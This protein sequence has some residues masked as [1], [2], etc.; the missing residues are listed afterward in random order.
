MKIAYIMLCHKNSKQINMLI[1][2]LMNDN[3]DFYIHVDLKSKIGNEISQK[4]NIFILP[5][6]KSYSVS[7]GGNEMILATLSLIREVKN[8]GKKYDY[9]WL[10]SGQDF[11]IVS[12]KIIEQRLMDNF[13]YNFIDI[14]DKEYK[15]YNA[16]KKL[17]EIKYPKWITKNKFYIKLI[18][19]IYMILTGGLKY[20]FKIFRRKRNFDFDFY[21][22]SQ[23]WT[24][25]SECAYDLLDYCDENP[26]YIKYFDN[27]I[28][29]DE[30]FFQTLFMNTKYSKLR[31]DNL[32]FVNW[33]NNKRSPENLTINDLS[34]LKQISKEKCLAR[35]FDIDVDDE[36]ILMLNENMDGDK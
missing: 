26:K 12:T 28:I 10:I 4:N 20:T 30:C 13:G 8:S 33:K 24:L 29:P 34:I 32:T 7:W 15:E 36:I 23:W 1:D 21:F 14:I 27:V 35:K 6:E 9:I 31:K 3:A 19:R 17:Y 25:T 2:K 22:G 18:K 11:P 5:K 16:Y